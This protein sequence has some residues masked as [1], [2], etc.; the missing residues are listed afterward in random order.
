MTS[1]DSSFEEFL[2]LPVLQENFLIDPVIIVDKEPW[3]TNGFGWPVQQGDS[4]ASPKPICP[5][6]EPP[7]PMLWDTPNS[8]QIREE[9]LADNTLA[10][11]NPHIH[12]SPPLLPSHPSAK[13]N[14]PCSSCVDE[15]SLSKQVKSLK[16]E[17]KELKEQTLKWPCIASASSTREG[18]C[19]TL[20]SHFLSLWLNQ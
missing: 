19:T 12:D 2:Q 15:G 8:H 14:A 7:S 20:H 16:Q 13:T 6:P 5:Y 18:S 11:G 3:E 4:L 17:V 1:S 9:R 10:E